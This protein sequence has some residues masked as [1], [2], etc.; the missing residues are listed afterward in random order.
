MRVVQEAASTHALIAVLTVIFILSVVAWVMTRHTDVFPGS[1]TNI[2]HLYRLLSA[3]DLLD[4]L[5]KEDADVDGLD[6]GEVERLLRGGGMVSSTYF[7]KDSD[8]DDDA[9][10]RVRFRL[11]PAAVQAGSRD[12]D[13]S[14]DGT[15]SVVRYRVYANYASEGGGS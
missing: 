5:A 12:D 13:S 14:K 4:G 2:A 3:G 11:G 8:T 6:D 15:K 9:P 10:G 7:V 1:P